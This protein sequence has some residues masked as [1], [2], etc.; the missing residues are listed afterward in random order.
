M[1]P[2]KTCASATAANFECQPQPWTAVISARQSWFDWKLRQLWTYRDLISLFVWR[3]FVSVYK[4]TILGP[5]WH[6]VQP[7][8]TTLMFTLVFSRVAQLSTDGVPPFLFYLSGTVPWYYFASTLT[9]TSNT[10]IANAQIMGKVYFHRLVIPVSVAIS[11][12]IAFFIQFSVFVV[13]LLYYN[14]SSGTSRITVW[15]AAFPFLLLL[16]AGFALGGGIIVSALTTRYRDLGNLVQ[17]GVQLLMFATP[18]I[19]PASSIPEHHRWISELNPLSPIIECFR[20]SFVGAGSVSP[21]D[22]AR[23]TVIMIVVFAVGLMLFNRV[24]RNFMDTV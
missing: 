3:D 6:V 12:L 17:F 23:S 11:G 24:E 14:I 21:T 4:Q 18:V 19:Y 10:F 5:A 22:L 2:E 1:F 9:K 8:L 13:I 7:L 20:L 16:L 15:A